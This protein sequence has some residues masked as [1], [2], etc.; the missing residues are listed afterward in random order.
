SG[1]RPGRPAPGPSPPASQAL[2]GKLPDAPPAPQRSTLRGTPPVAA[3]GT[4]PPPPAAS[5]PPSPRPTHRTGADPPPRRRG[6]AGAC[7]A[8][9]IR[10]AALP[11]QVPGAG[12][13]DQS[14]DS[15]APAR[16]RSPA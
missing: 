10:G 14:E 1:R 9:A 2:A 11:A 8:W 3:P 16:D 12:P 15:A 4:G 7:L 5:V 13:A 6:R